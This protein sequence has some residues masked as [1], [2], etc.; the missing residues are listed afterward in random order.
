[1]SAPYGFTALTA[2]GPLRATKVF[3]LDPLTGEIETQGYGNAKEFEAKD[4]TF[5]DIED[6]ERK[7]RIL[8][9]RQKTCVVR[10]KLRPGVDGART[11]R[12]YRPEVDEK[13]TVI[14]PATFEECERAVVM[15][16]MDLSPA[17]PDVDPVRDAAGARAFVLGL[18]P[19]EFQDVDL[20]LSW[21]SSQNVKPGKLSAHVWALFDRAVADEELRRWAK[22]VNADWTARRTPEQPRKLID[23]AVFRPV[24]PHYTAAPLFGG[25]LT[26]PFGENR[27][28]LVRGSRPHVTLVTLAPTPPSPPRSREGMHA[29]RGFEEHLDRIGSDEGFHAPLMSAIGAYVR[30]HGAR[31]TDPAG[32]IAAVRDRILEADPGGRDEGE[33]ARYASESFLRQK[34][35]WAIRQDQAPKERSFGVGPYEVQDGRIVFKNETSKGTETHVLTNFTARITEEQT[36]DDGAEKRSVFLITGALDTGAALPPARV[37]SSSFAGMGWVGAA[38]G[39]R[40]FIVAGASAKDRTREAIQRLSTP[41]SRIL[42]G[43]TGWRS[44]GRE[45]VFLH[46]GGGLAESGPRAEIEV[47]LSGGL[48]NVELADQGDAVIEDLRSVLSTLLSV[49]PLR[50][51]LPALAAAFRAPLGEALRIDLALYI[52]GI[53]GVF[54]TCL[55]ALAQAFFGAAFDDRN[56]PG[57]WMSTANALERS[58][59]LAKD[60]LFVIDDYAPRGSQREVAELGAKGERLLRAIGNV[61]GRGR[62]NVDGS[63]RA[64]YFPRCLAIITG[65]DIPRGQSARARAF[66]VEIARGDVDPTRLS[67]AQ[68]LAA[69]GAFARVMAGYVRWLAPQIRTIG[70]ALRD[71]LH[72]LRSRAGNLSHRRTPDQA[73]SLFLG[74]EQ[75]LRFAVEIGA[76]EQVEADR[77]AQVWWRE[78]CDVAGAQAGHHE[79]ADPPRRFLALLTDMLLSGAAHLDDVTEGGAPKG[80]PERWGFGRREVRLN[81]AVGSEVRY[82]GMGDRLGW[83]DEQAGALYLLPDAAYAA[84]QRFAS[85]QG[86]PFAL[87]PRTLWKAMAE[88]G[89][90]GARELV[91]KGRP[92]RRFTVKKQL[93]GTGDSRTPVLHVLLPPSRT[94]VTSGPSGTPR[95]ASPVAEA[96][97]DPNGTDVTGDPTGEFPLDERGELIL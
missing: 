95:K 10:G 32:L 53:T 45:M 94:T 69:E 83:V 78:L 36:I 18:L 48:A 11:R 92:V 47:D 57:G 91:E 38:W 28:T 25:G 6:L 29:S 37:P 72:G 30:E 27:L 7:L 66:I 63:L 13:G 64:N 84:L 22:A 58:A 17:P 68:K 87:A 26:D 21:G 73:A 4:V 70:T 90:L 76:Y 34:V 19:P 20:I 44:V 60:I 31:G 3:C 52:A 33:I 16:D 23:E 5:S 62:M 97:Q 61:S 43:H 46:A 56:L 2:R 40:P 49:A 81:G 85:A 1:M 35:E 54:K 71:R 39:A 88:A 12:L 80:E 65:E 50:V 86:E 55:A 82:E 93:P 77:L 67:A 51:M 14:T 42:F 79:D 15:L 89:L 75:L 41:T 24:Q 74:L 8:Q 96:S 59:F 9:R